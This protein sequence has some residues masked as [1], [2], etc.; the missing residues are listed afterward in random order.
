MTDTAEIY[1]FPRG[2]ESVR[3]KRGPQVEDGYTRIANELYKVIN[4]RHTFPGTATHLRIV[5]AIIARTY[6]FNKTM[7]AIAD[8][9]I[10]ADT[11]VPRQKVNPAKIELLAMRVLQ[12]SDDGRLIGINKRYHEWDF[13]SRPEKKAPERTSRQNGDTVTKKVTKEVTKTGTHNRQIDSLSTDVEREA[14]KTRRQ[15][16]D[17]NA[18]ADQVSID[19]LQAFAD[20]RRALRSPLTQRALELTV[21]AA[22]QAAGELNITVEHAI[23]EAI[24]AGWK[25]VRTEWLRNRGVDKPEVAQDIPAC[26][27]AEILAIWNDTCGPIKGAAPHLLDWKGTNSANALAERWAEFYNAEVNGKVRYDSVE[28]GLAWWRMALGHIAGL[29]DFRSADID[30]WSAFYK[31]RFSKAARGQLCG[32]GGATR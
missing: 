7:D 17:L 12:L 4:N 30:I 8:T 1:Q 31:T 20:H 28:T 11:G 3:E 10:A 13:S 29:Q 16:L 14:P 25:T 19:T 5:H 24:A 2:Q 27:H 6:G 9:Q 22:V 26:P 15:R 18:F 23:D 32:Q 21:K